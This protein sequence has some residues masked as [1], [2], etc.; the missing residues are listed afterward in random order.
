[1]VK[2]LKM[3]KNV[4]IIVDETS[5]KW[6]IW[7]TNQIRNQKNNSLDQGGHNGNHMSYKDEILKMLELLDEIY[8]RY[9]YKLL[10]EMIAK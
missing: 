7:F 10:K 6:Y 1:M 9:I 3:T 5:C 8:L 2:Q 4:K